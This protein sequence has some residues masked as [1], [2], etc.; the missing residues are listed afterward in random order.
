MERLDV[1]G[2]DIGD[3]RLPLVDVLYFSLIEVDARDVKAGLGQLHGERESHVSES[4]DARA[5]L[6]RPNLVANGVY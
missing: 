2:G 3:V 5:R 4:D 6:A 1:G